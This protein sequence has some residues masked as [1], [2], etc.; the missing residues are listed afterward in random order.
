MHSSRRQFLSIATSGV[1]LAAISRRSAA[2]PYPVKPV[3][4]VVGYP[5]GGPIDIV[6]RIVAEGLSQ[7]MGQPFVIDNR[8]GAG[9]NVGAESVVRAPADG[10]TLLLVGSNN[11]IN[12]TLYDRLGFNFMRDIAPVGS[13]SLTPLVME[14]HPAVPV[15]SVAEF[16][17][18][19]K[20]NPGRLNMASGGVG[21]PVH[22]AGE[23]FKMIAG[24]NMVHVS[25]RGSAPALADLIS[26]QVQ[27]MFDTV[28]S[29][30]PHIK[31]GK[32]RP[33]AVTT[34]T[35]LA[36]LP[37]IPTVAES[38]PGY[39]VISLQGLGAPRGTPADVIDMLYAAL[40]QALGD[41]GVRARF[42]ELGME[43]FANGPAAFGRLIAD[44]T[45]KWA[46]VVKFA[47]AKVE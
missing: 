40:G 8:P 38:L 9:G 10:Y 17:A 46:K 19:A 16:I 44:E 47:G 21:T 18:Y 29:S 11:F 12:A 5:A 15:T 23:L 13:I 4:I 41:A 20:A 22:M 28:S 36:V 24:V 33:L 31:T 2:Q 6:G 39:E 14:V 3:K 43:V 26:G 1:T 27:V 7:R 42:T 30:L 32:L 35:R 45:E 25:Y 37:G 34:S